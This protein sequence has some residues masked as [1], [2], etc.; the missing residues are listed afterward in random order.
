M[1]SE[2]I[3]GQTCLTVW[4]ISLKSHQIWEERKKGIIRN[5]NI[6]VKEQRPTSGLMILSYTDKLWKKGGYYRQVRDCLEQVYVFHKVTREKIK[7]SLRQYYE[8][9][10]L[11]CQSLTLFPIRDR[12]VT[13]STCTD[14]FDFILNSYFLFEKNRPH[15]FS[16][17][18]NYFSKH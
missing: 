14:Q 11:D 13:D 18:L 10:E 2:I 8:T 5:A 4:L 7:A 3:R 16:F 17:D 15:S 9:T 6:T 12:D 1:C